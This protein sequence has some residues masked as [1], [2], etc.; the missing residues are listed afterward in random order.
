MCVTKDR[1][2]LAMHGAGL[3]GPVFCVVGN[4]LEGVMLG[5]V[6]VSFVVCMARCRALVCVTRYHVRVSPAVMLQQ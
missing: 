6:L 1:V 5:S 2:L 4:L 3:V